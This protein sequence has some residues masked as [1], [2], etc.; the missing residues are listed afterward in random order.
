MIQQLHPDKRGEPWWGLG[1]ELV[2]VGGYVEFAEL[3]GE[4]CLEDGWE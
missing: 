2:L 1:E 4:I 3:V